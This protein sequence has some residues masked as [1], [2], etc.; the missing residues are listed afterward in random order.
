MESFVEIKMLKTKQNNG[1]NSFAYRYLFSKEL[2][3]ARHIESVCYKANPVQVRREMLGQWVGIIRKTER[4]VDEYKGWLERSGDSN[5]N[6][7]RRWLQRTLQ[8]VV[9]IKRKVGKCLILLKQVFGDGK[10]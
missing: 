5:I 3:S 4:A 10:E 7:Y 2:L 1:D 9:Q 8:T 6:I